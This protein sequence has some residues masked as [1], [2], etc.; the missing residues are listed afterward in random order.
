[1]WWA[2]GGAIALAA[3]SGG[4]LPRQPV[5]PP[6]GWLDRA[7]GRTTPATAG[8]LALATAVLDVPAPD[9]YLSRDLWVS[10]AAANPLRA[11]QTTLL[12]LNGL[13][14]R[15][16]SGLVPAPLQRLLDAD[17]TA[18]G[19]TARS[20]PPGRPKVVPVNGPL[21]AVAF[22]V[23]ADL[24]A[25]PVPATRAAAE[26]GLSIT[27]RPA[28]GGRVLLRCE[29]QVQHGDRQ[30]WFR[31]L[32]DGSGFAGQDARPLD[33]YPSL[34]WDVVLGPADLLIVGP[35]PDPTGTL[36]GAFFRAAAGD[37]V[38]QR[39]LVVRAVGGGK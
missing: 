34:A 36:G 6:G 32:A 14:V 9:D 7:T 17:D 18:V 8:G 13:R 16:V 24:T 12:E 33:A 35:T 30:R 20:A 23:R 31:P 25:D 2:R 39:V 22:A 26:C 28:D 27:P 21:P 19:R 29:P 4:C 37:Q 3:V 15:V 5:R 38:R 10:A 11:D 1:M